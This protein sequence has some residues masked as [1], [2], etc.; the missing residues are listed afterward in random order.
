MSG[1]HAEALHKLPEELRVLARVISNRDDAWSL[2]SIEEALIKA[3]DHI[4]HLR[5]TICAATDCLHHD[6][7]K[8]ARKILEG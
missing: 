5:R 8:Q 3:A 2:E 6:D 4:E 7:P 1:P